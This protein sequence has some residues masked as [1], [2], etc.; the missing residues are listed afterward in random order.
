MSHDLAELADSLVKVAQLAH[1]ELRP[2]DVKTELLPSPHRRPSRLPAGVQAVY[3]FML[4]EHCLKVG[5]A[6][7][8]TQARF[9]SQHY[10]KSAPSTLA[11]S[12]LND[13]S[14]VAALLGSDCRAEVD[15]LTD[16]SVG[17]WIEANTSRVHVVI[18]AVAGDLVL[19]LVESFVQCRFRPIFEGKSS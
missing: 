11:K 9:T 17:A 13:R 5:K 19:G 8:K 3:A 10:D 14:R 4:G 6:G 7:P 12:I 15:R 18:P 1:V 2:G 16:N